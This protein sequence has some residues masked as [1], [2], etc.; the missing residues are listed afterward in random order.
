VEAV[1]SWTLIALLVICC[2]MGA[3]WL[4]FLIVDVATRIRA[5]FHVY[6][7][8]RWFRSISRSRSSWYSSS[9]SSG[10]GNGSSTKPDMTGPRPRFLG[11]P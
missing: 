7:M 6:R 9:D 10:D 11:R 2:F 3:V 5:W 8:E 1:L 4:A